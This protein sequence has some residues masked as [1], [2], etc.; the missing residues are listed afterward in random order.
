MKKM[1]RS[2]LKQFENFLMKAYAESSDEMLIGV[3]SS[4]GSISVSHSTSIE[5]GIEVETWSIS[6]REFG[7]TSLPKF[8]AFCG[9]YK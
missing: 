4:G 1:S 9:F 2:N 7:E 3:N 5:N 8:P 6:G